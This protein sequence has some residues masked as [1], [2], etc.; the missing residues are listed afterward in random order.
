[1]RVVFFGVG[2]LVRHDF[3]V[4][5][6]DALGIADVSL[7][8]AIYDEHGIVAEAINLALSRNLARTD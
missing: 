5:G 8:E 2:R 6:L 7:K 3:A 4:N 1:M